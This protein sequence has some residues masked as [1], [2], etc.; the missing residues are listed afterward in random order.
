MWIFS[1]I[2][3]WVNLDHVKQI[4][5]SIRSADFED[6]YVVRAYFASD[7]GANYFATLTAYFTEAESD[8]AL[9][10]LEET[11]RGEPGGYIINVSPK[12]KEV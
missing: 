1:E 2:S 7:P 6:R 11:L 9:R 10:D 8:A 4:D 12:T 3:G 5:K